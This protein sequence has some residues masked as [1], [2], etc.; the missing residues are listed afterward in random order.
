[1][2]QPKF[3]YGYLVV[4]AAFFTMAAMFGLYYAFGI[5]FKPVLTEFGWTRAMTSGA[6]SLSWIVS[7]FLAIAMGGLTDKFGPRIVMTLS[8]IILGIGY[9]LMSQISAIWQLYLFYGVI[10]GIGMGGSFVPLAST[11]ARWFVRKRSTMTG[12]VLAGAGVGTLFAPPIANWLISTHDWRASYTILGSVVM[13]IVILA[14]QFLRRD[15]AQVK[16][17]PY[18]KEEA[19]LGLKLITKGFSLK[20]AVRTNQFWLVFSMFFCLACPVYAIMVHIVPHTIDLGISASSAANLLATIGG[21]SIVGKVVLGG[22]ADRIGNKQA[23]II[24]FILMSAALFLLVP[25][26]QL[27]ALCL[28]VIAFGFAYGG[29]AASESPLVAVLF[30]LRSQGTILGVLNLG[31]TIGAAVGPFMAGFIFD[32]TG[33]YQLAFWVCGAISIVGFTL[34]KLLPKSALT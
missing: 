13:V 22:A 4:V 17:V 21:L 14:A 28:L 2:V 18:G 26:T 10:I 34:A 16:Q 11:V 19:E 3:F 9:L 24:G 8:G 29:C 30:G 20:E 6:F 32:I 33:N 31:Y 27:W 7:G 25:A 1:M 23:F 15:P 12:I 5:F